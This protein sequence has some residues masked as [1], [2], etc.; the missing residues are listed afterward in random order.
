MQAEVMKRR[1]VLETR[2]IELEQNIIHKQR[3]LDNLRRARTSYT[4]E[5]IDSLLQ[6]KADEVSR[7]RSEMDSLG[8]DAR[9][10]IDEQGEIQS[11]LDDL[12]LDYGDSED[13]GLEPDDLDPDY[14]RVRDIARRI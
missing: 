2:M 4:G 8:A 1:E 13:G 9:Q 3:A 12:R 7:L 6:S 5:D 10:V 14:T 11:R